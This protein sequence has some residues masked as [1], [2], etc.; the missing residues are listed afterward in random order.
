MK[1]FCSTIDKTN[2]EVASF[3]VAEIVLVQSNL[4]ENQY[5]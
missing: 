1:L 4:A 5:Q 2:N 3:E